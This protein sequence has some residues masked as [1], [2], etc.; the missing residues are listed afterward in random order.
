MKLRMVSY[1]PNAPKQV[2]EI[3]ILEG[4]ETVEVTLWTYMTGGIFNAEVSGRLLGA[5]PKKVVET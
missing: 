1:K 5:S 2:E 4:T 3:E